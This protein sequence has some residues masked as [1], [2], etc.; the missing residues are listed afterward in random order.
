LKQFPLSTL[1]VF[2]FLAAAALPPQ[3]KTKK[4]AQTTAAIG[5]R[6]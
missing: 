3:P 2:L 1:A 4:R 6:K 5:A